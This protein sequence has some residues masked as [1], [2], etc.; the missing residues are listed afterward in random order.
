MLWKYASYLEENTNAK[1]WFNQVFLCSARNSYQTCSIK[2]AALK[3]SAI[4]TGK[5]LCWNLFLI[6]LQAFGC[7]LWKL[8]NLYAA[9]LHWTKSKPLFRS[10]FN[11]FFTT[12]SDVQGLPFPVDAGR[13]LNVHKTFRRR[14]GHLRNVLCTFNL[15]SVPTRFLCSNSWVFVP[16]FFYVW[17]PL[18]VKHI[19][20]IKQ[21]SQNNDWEALSIFRK[22]LQRSHFFQLQHHKCAAPS[23]VL[24][25]SNTCVCS[26]FFRRNVLSLDFLLS[27]LIHLHRETLDKTLTHNWNNW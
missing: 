25:D 2:K 9:F 6:K 23:T 19:H 7:F 12:Y 18:S 11:S 26:S 15:R 24:V 13:K 4:F 14:P 20:Q 17:H 16:V 3:N 1:V 21:S 8:R 22:F 10:I 27:A 5:D